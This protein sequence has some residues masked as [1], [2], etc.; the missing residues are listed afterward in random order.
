MDTKYSLTTLLNDLLKLQNNGY[1]IISKLSEIVSSNAD[2]V[3]I[4]ITDNNGV[5][6]TVAVPS[7]GS[8]KNQL[9]RLENNIES[10]SGI[11]ADSSVRLADGTFRKVLVSKL[12]KEAADIKSMP[13]PIG[14]STRENWFFES[15]LNPLL[16]VKFDLTNQIKFNTENVEVARY[17]LNIDSDAKKKIYNDT[18]LK[19]I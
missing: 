10:L 4:P 6:Q 16:Y 14:F 19:Q 9:V 15:F 1:Q 8:I 18:F 2:T 3:Q 12:Q 7:F 17:I 5:V 13:L 11:G